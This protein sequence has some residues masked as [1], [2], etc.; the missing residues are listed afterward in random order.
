MR[1]TLLIK[2]YGLILVLTTAIAFLHYSHE[3]TIHEL[4]GVYKLFFFVPIILAAFR[5]GK[6][7]GLVISAVVAAAFF[8][9][10][11]VSDCR[12]CGSTGDKTIEMALYFGVGLLTGT[13]SDHLTNARN[14]LQNTLDEKSAME[15]KLLRAT[16]MAAVGRLS[17]GLAHEIRNPLASIQGSAEVLADDFDSNHPKG[18]MMGILQDEAKRL[19]SVLT[20]FLEF[21]RTEPGDL[22][23]FDLKKEV[24]AVIEMIK[25]HPDFPSV[26][27]SLETEGN[28]FSAVG[29][30]EQI[31]QVL[32]NL[33]LNGA[34]A[35]MPEGQV[36]FQLNRSA[37]R[38]VCR[39]TDTGSGFSDEACE[40]FGTP[41]FSTKDQGTGLG[42]A[43]SLKIVQDQG[44]SLEPGPANSGFGL[45][46]L[47]LP[48]ENL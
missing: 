29:N 40:Q 5:G 4:H 46:I 42:L 3:S 6:I 45:V 25:H 20:R 36:V 1:L 12:P 27:C 7:G 35:A 32:L 37:Q 41:F 44:G 23:P 47:D 18:R 15:A 9:H 19:N 31:R 34:S 33:G 11:F 16:R 22:A 30:P 17:A 2:K 14:L 8:P 43:T 10:A 28:N 26:Q 39:V 48:A 13:L 24:E 21:A 38:I